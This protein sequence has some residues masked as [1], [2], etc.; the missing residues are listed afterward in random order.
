MNRQRL[1]IAA[2]AAVLGLLYWQS[3]REVRPAAVP[4]T[5]PTARASDTPLHQADFIGDEV[6]GRIERDRTLQLHA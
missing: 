3:R 2:L 5:L 4:L 6:P 1:I